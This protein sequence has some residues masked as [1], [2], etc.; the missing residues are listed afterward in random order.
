[1]W[2]GRPEPIGGKFLLGQMLLFRKNTQREHYLFWNTFCAKGR[3]RRNCQ[4]NL[5]CFFY[6][7]CVWNNINKKNVITIKHNDSTVNPKIHRWFLPNLFIVIYYSFI[8][9]IFY[10]Y[11][12]IKNKIKIEIQS[13]NF[14]Y[15]FIYLMNLRISNTKSTCKNELL[16]YK[17]IYSFN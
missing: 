5:I 9:N 14:F 13:N 4:R 12:F 17:M 2:C 15:K 16:F 1:M 6:T 11:F 10:N 8:V 3:N 7:R